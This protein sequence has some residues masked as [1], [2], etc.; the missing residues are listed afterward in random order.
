MVNERSLGRLQNPANDPYPEPGEPVRI[1]VFVSSVL[2]LSSQ[3]NLGSPEGLFH[4][5]TVLYTLYL[6]AACPLHFLLYITLVLLCEEY[7]L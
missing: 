5:G 4:P 7:K 6:L 2:M 3:L 1:P